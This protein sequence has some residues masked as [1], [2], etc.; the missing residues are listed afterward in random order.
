MNG[1]K[2]GTLARMTGTGL[3]QAAVVIAFGL[4]V[5]GFVLIRRLSRIDV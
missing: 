2:D 1:V 3:G 5:I 4:Y